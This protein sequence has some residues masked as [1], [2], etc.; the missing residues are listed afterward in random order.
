MDPRISRCLVS[1]SNWRFLLLRSRQKPRFLPAE[2][3]LMSEKAPQATFSNEI[4]PPESDTMLLVIEALTKSYPSRDG[5]SLALAEINFGIEEGEFVSLV[6]PS[7]CGKSTILTLAAGLIPP[8]TGRITLDG[9][10]VVKAGADR[11]MVFQQANLFPWLTVFENVTFGLTLKANR[12]P[13]NDERVLLAQADS[14]LQAV[15]LAAF[16]D[17]YPRQLSGGMR[18]RAALVRALV[19]RP[20]ILLMDEPFGALDAQTR[21]EMQELLMHL[22]RRQGTTVLFVTH[23]VE[24]ALILSDR[25]LVMQAHP[26]AIIAEVPV[27]LERPRQ[28][29]MRADPIFV[30]LRARMFDL[31]HHR[32]RRDISQMVVSNGT[33]EAENRLRQ[34]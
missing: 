15:G 19:T 21:E 31:L 18:Q 34:A 27:S 25:V 24:E 32:V 30:E 4:A 28:L 12:V 1:L 5:Q 8:S 3:K 26:G 23:D 13:R 7:G 20:R 10:T 16:R 14:L 6:G 29:D 2:T 9:S 11:G 22:C 33:A 17:H